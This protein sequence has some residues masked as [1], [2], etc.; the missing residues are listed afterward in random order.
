MRARQ[1]SLISWLPMRRVNLLP[2]VHAQRALV[3]G[4]DYIDSLVQP[5]ATYLES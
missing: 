1:G 3:M 4:M 5:P 2:T